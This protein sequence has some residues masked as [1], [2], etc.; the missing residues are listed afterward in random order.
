VL[1]SFRVGR[2]IY[3]HVRQSG[4]WPATSSASWI[5]SRTTPIPIFLRLR[6]GYLRKRL[7]RQLE[8]RHL[9]GTRVPI[10]FRPVNRLAPKFLD[11]GSRP[12]PAKLW[13][14]SCKL[15]LI[16]SAIRR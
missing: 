8:I 11:S 1:T 2:I 15:L 12:A 4:H 10:G 9:L 13:V 5:G 16:F 3:T 6:S 14:N 7:L